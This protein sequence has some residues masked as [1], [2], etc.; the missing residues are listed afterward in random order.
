[1]IQNAGPSLVCVR[2][3]CLLLLMLL[4]VTPWQGSAVPPVHAQDT[5]EIAFVTLDASGNA[6]GIDSMRPDGSGRRTIWSYPGSGGGD[7]LDVEWN[8]DATELAFSSDHEGSASPYSSDVYGIRPDGSQLRRIT[9]PPALSTLADGTFA[10]GTVNVNLSNLATDTP[11]VVTP[12]IIYVQGAAEGVSVTLPPRNESTL[13]EIPNVA[14]L[15]GT[16][17]VIATWAGGGCNISKFVAAPI[18]VLA[19]ETVTADLPFDGS[20]CNTIT[21]SANN[22]LSLSWQRDSSSIG[23]SVDARPALVDP[24]VGTPETW[25]AASGFVSSPVFSP[26]DD[27]VLYESGGTASGIFLVPANDGGPGTQ[28]LPDTSISQVIDWLP[29]G[30]GFVYLSAG[31]L[32]VYDIA[33]QQ[34]GE[35]AS[36]TDGSIQDASVSPDGNAVAITFTANGTQNRDIYV[37]D[38][39]DPSNPTSTP[40]TTDGRSARPTWS[41]TTPTT[42]APETWSIAGT[43]TDATS[44]PLAG[45]VI[46]ANNGDQV[47]TADDGAYSFTGLMQGTYTLTPTLEGYTFEPPSITV[48]VPPDAAGQDFT[49]TPD[50]PGTPTDPVTFSIAG[51][52]AQDDSNP[53]AGVTIS[54]NMGDIATTTSSGTY[55]FTGLV[56]GTYTLTPTLEGYTFE[57]PSIIVA[58]PPDAAGQDFTA[59]AVPGANATLSSNH[60]EGQPG[61]AFVFNGQ[62]FPIS[63]SVRVR[64]NDVD[65]A[66]DPPLMTDSRGMITFVLDTAGLEPG[67]YSVTLRSTANHVGLTQATS[68][69]TTI[70]LIEDAPLREADVGSDVPAIEVPNTVQPTDD[71]RVYLPFIRR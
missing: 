67:S 6:T 51:M 8:P 34:S 5:T 39:T 58:V 28:L 24:A 33:S 32:R 29:D 54:A 12:F 70:T 37:L 10:T 48:A 55:T 69:S 53:V 63:T 17:Y 61:S 4:A 14:D 21:T 57:P 23:Y 27:R 18:T 56:T 62:S 47:T 9:N 60:T 64:V 3:S 1:M 20:V 19:G 31:T 52:V 46:A 40:L 7:I 15:E 30:S 68:A 45:V 25:F 13:V 41:S 49:A 16:Q 59:T 43:V 11:S 36:F 71:Q 50:D 42:P 22:V 66:F 44:G 2:A 38:F 35:L 26:V 65:L